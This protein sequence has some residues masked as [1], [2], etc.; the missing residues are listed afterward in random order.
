MALK[1]PLYDIHKKLGAKFTEFA[2]FEMPLQFSSINEEHINVRKNAGLF[3]VSHM[4][5]VWINGK[6]ADKL[7]TLTTMEDASKV[8]IGRSQY[9]AILRENGTIIDDT[10]FMHI[11]DRFMLIPN[12]G[13]SELVANWLNTQAE[14]HDL[15]A[16]AENV[17]QDFAIIAIQGPKSRDIIQKFTNEDLSKIGFF[18]CKN[19]KFA[20]SDLILSFTG[21]TGELGYELQIDDFNEAKKIFE[22]ILE[23]GEDFGIKPVG[24]GAR[25]TLRMEKFFLLAGNEFQGGRTPLEANI[26]FFLNWDHDFI[27]KKALQEQKENGSYERL[28]ALLC[29]EKGIPRHG[30]TV[31]KEGQNIG[32]VSSGTMSPCLNKGIAMAYIKPGF[33][34][35]DNEVD[36][37]IREKKVKAKMIKPPFV[38]KDWAQKN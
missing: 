32:I 12:A 3:D 28:T 6:D 10:I 16:E 30:C 26:S 22:K 27:G 37:I 35:I 29:E 19:I 21:Y 4:G 38:S 13:Q 36:I 1:S 7:L 34:K 8:G 31:E 18:G 5:N 33:I 14:K 15:D 25:D 17:S 11:D 24:L 20:G 9:T 2:G 23:V